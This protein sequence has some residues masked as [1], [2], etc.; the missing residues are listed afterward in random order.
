MKLKVANICGCRHAEFEI[1]EKVPVIIRGLN[2]SGKSSVLLALMVLLTRNTNPLNLPAT[3]KLRYVT[4]GQDEAGASLVGSD[5]SLK[6]DGAGEVEETGPVPLT[7]GMVSSHS[8]LLLTGKPSSTA[9]QSILGV[10]IKQE[11]LEGLLRTCLQ[12]RFPEWEK[13]AEELVRTVFY[14][15]GEDGWKTALGNAS[16]RSTAAKQKWAEAVAESGEKAT[17]GVRIGGQWHPKSWTVEC[18]ELTETVALEIVREAASKLEEARKVRHITEDQLASRNELAVKINDAQRRFKVLEDAVREI[19][20]NLKKERELWV[21]DKEKA[22]KHAEWVLGRTA[23]RDKLESI[24]A[25]LSDLY[26]QEQKDSV[27]EDLTD[28]PHCGR[29]VSIRMGQ[30]HKP[31]HSH[32][33]EARLNDL[34]KQQALCE[35][36]LEVKEPE[37]SKGLEEPKSLHEMRKYQDGMALK[38]ELKLMKEELDGYPDPGSAR[39]G[40]A[41]D[42]SDMEEDYN[43]ANVRLHAV[44]SFRK[45]KDAH[46]EIVSWEAVRKILGP[47]GVRSE[48][49][50]EKVNR[51]NRISASMAVKAGEAWSEVALNEKTWQLEVGKTP[52][53]LCSRSEKWRAMATVAMVISFM[54]N[55]PVC[56]IDDM[57]TLVGVDKGHDTSEGMAKAIASLSSLLPIVAA[58]A[59]DSDEDDLS[60]GEGDV[61]MVKGVQV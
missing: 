7:H 27:E 52:V 5:W 38:T 23:L 54:A 17:W 4:K 1:K 30:L 43:R 37:G 8:Y 39:V 3:S 36:R 51:F 56:I 14:T 29:P 10:E 49:L 15:G 57:D 6:W 28:C 21:A 44:T 18:E 16:Y 34:K 40:E 9:W 12:G 59:A 26:R 58:Y 46:E 45:A 50:G 60:H 24:N 47:S 61:R 41:E 32:D 11:H 13:I 35:A 53:T 33:D 20:V 25:E 19:N 22:R 31:A 48:V 42:L 55:S 2:E